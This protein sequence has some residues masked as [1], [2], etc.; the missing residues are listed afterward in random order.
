[1][2][3]KNL[4]VEN[5]SGKAI[6]T[7][8][9]NSEKLFVIKRKDNHR[10]EFYSDLTR[11]DSNKIKYVLIGEIAKQDLASRPFELPNN[12]RV[13]I[14]SA[15]DH[16]VI[17]DEEVE[18]ENPKFFFTIWGAF[19]LIGFLSITLLKY[20]PEPTAAIQNDLERRMVKIVKKERQV[21]VQSSAENFVSKT[22]T[23]PKVTLK[24]LGALAALGS[25]MKSNQKG[26][27]NLGA[28]NTTAGIGLGGT[29]GSGGVQTS[30]YG[31]GIVAAPVG[32]G[33]NIKGAGGY[34]TKGKGGG[35]AGYGQLSLVG[36]AGNSAF[37]IERVGTDSGGLD[38]D[39]IAEVV[40][41]NQGQIMFC[42]EQGLQASPGL[43]GRV[44]V[45]WTIGSEGQV[46]VAKVENTSLASKMVEDCIVMRLKTW[47]FP[48]P[49]GGVDV[50]VTYPFV[51]K[52]AGQ[53]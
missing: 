30:L 52:R 38:R 6:R 25:L 32:T 53:G 18:E 46:K 48:L 12:Y 11:L 13:R 2:T 51:L 4:I 47:K 20:I 28:V 21:Q 40:R 7:V 34:G 15:D 24:R 29:Q 41:R 42:Y 26:G 9:L 44:A 49:E 3:S 17:A 10:I 35:Q 39:A 43:N 5:Q 1:M 33:G 36:S 50:S 45:R 27:L 22:T 23:K 37:A 16:V 19:L 31:K 8:R 14:A